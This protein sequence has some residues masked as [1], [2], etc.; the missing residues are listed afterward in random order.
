MSDEF[1]QKSI[2][3]FNLKIKYYC[4]KINNSGRKADTKKLQ[5]FLKIVLEG[6]K[7]VWH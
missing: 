5:D 4:D 1:T 7:D 3:F 6:Q 2:F